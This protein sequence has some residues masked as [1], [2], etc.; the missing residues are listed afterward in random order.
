MKRVI[1]IGD[2]HQVSLLYASFSRGIRQLSGQSLSI[3]NGSNRPFCSCAL[4]CQAFDLEWGWRWPRGRDQYLV[5]VITNWFKFDKRRGLYNNKVNL[6]LIPVQRLGNQALKV[7]WTIVAGTYIG[8]NKALFYISLFFFCIYLVIHLCICIYIY[9]FKFSAS[10][11]YK[12]HGFSEVFQHGAISFHEICQTLCSH[13]WTRCSR[14]CTIQVWIIQTSPDFIIKPRDQSMFISGG[15]GSGKV[16]GDHMV[17]REPE[18]EL[19]TANG[20]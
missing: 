12:E 18:G 1:L 3:R 6:R 13:S 16:L 15:G 20:I 8:S 17:F 7:K 10:S 19:V 4:S 11:C 9:F 2:H 14:S 5:S